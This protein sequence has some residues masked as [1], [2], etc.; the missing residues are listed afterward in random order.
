LRDLAFVV[1]EPG[2]LSRELELERHR[3]AG[4]KERAQ[5][6]AQTGEEVIDR[7][8]RGAERGLSC[9]QLGEVEQV[10]DEDGERL[11]RLADVV[12]L[13]LLLA[14]ELAIRFG[15]QQLGQPEHRVERRAELVAHVGQHPRLHLGGAPQRLGLVGELGVQCDHAAVRFLEL[16]AEPRQPRLGGGELLSEYFVGADLVGVGGVGVRQRV[17]PSNTACPGVADESSICFPYRHT[18]ALAMCSRR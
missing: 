5:R 12:H 2:Q 15:E 6:A 16:L 3:R 18:R 1:L 13:L 8:G 14:A 4:R 17:L 10:V 9:L 7:E 11:G